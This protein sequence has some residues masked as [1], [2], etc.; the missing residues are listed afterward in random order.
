MPLHFAQKHIIDFFGG[1]FRHSAEAFRRD[2]SRFDI[3]LVRD[4]R[5]RAS[6]KRGPAFCYMVKDVA[7]AIR[8][9]TQYDEM[10]GLCPLDQRECVVDDTIVQIRGHSRSGSIGGQNTRQLPPLSLRWN[11]TGREQSLVRPDWKRGRRRVSF[12]WM[13]R[14]LLGRNTSVGRALFSY[15]QPIYLTPTLCARILRPS[16]GWSRGKWT[17]LAA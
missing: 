1:C 12:L 5:L 10:P 15:A 13:I 9:D 11:G 6:S 3:H 17:V 2:H 7:E 16:Q 4:R 14:L 8:K